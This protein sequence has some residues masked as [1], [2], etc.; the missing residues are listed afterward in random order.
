MEPL[1]VA[2]R[3]VVGFAAAYAVVEL[4]AVALVFVYGDLPRSLQARG[5]V[6]TLLVLGLAGFAV[7]IGLVISLVSWVVAV[8]RAGRE[9]GVPAIGLLGPWA[10]G[11]SVIL[12]GFGLFELP[13][14]T[15]TAVAIRLLCVA[16]LIVGV[17]HTAA[18]AR[19]RDSTSAPYTAAPPMSARPTA[20]DWDAS[21]W[22]PDVQRDIERRR[23]HEGN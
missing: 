9:Q 23:H 14:G 6:I 7:V 21:V 5:V 20:Q 4:F 3:R 12:W 18:W 8:V 11:A 10:I 16:V 22:D 19:G 17:R 1:Y 2:T 15:F 13:G